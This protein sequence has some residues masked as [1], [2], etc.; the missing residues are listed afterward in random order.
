MRAMEIEDFERLDDLPIFPLATVL[1][2]G[3]VL[4]LHI[5]EERYKAMIR[6]AID[7]GGVFGLSYRADAQ[8]DRETVLN[9]GSVGCVAKINGV[10]PLEEGRMNIIT[11]GVIRYRLV[12]VKQIVPFLTA[13]VEVLEDDVEVD[14]DLD[15]LFNEVKRLCKSFLKTVGIMD[16]AGS[17][18]DQNLPEDP[19]SFSLL[20]SSLIPIDNESKQNLLETT[21]TKFRLTRLKHLVVDAITDYNKGQQVQGRAK[22]NGHSTLQQ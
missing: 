21:S 9:I 6:F 13:R 20:L 22:N 2:P 19:Q 17:R 3:A 1:F 11:T 8:V 18:F 5:F 16:E 15:D 4:P 14:Q 10:V 12:D 7:N